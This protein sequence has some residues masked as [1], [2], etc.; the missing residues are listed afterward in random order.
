M[1][2][3]NFSLGPKGDLSRVALNGGFVLRF[4]LVDATL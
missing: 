4:Q 2:S 1:V 3:L